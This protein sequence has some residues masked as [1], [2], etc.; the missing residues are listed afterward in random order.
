MRDFESHLKPGR[1]LGIWYPYSPNNNKA[2]AQGRPYSHVVL[3]YGKIN[4][5]HWVLHNLNGPKFEPLEEALSNYPK[6]G[7]GSVQEI[8]EP[9]K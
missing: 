9:K 8:I 5:V 2:K 4:G 6:L 1:I 7:E 3:Y